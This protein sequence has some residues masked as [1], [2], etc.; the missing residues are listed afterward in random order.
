MPGGCRHNGRVTSPT[1]SP[2][3]AL[4]RGLFDLDYIGAGLAFADALGELSDALHAGGPAGTA[5][6][7]APPGTGKTTLVPPLL[8]NLAAGGRV[9]ERRRAGARAPRVVVTQP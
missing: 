1:V 4:S 9:Q 7:Q 6:V 3:S 5:V 8:A 2:G